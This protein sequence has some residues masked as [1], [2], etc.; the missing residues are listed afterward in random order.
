[1]AHQL[2]IDQVKAN[3]PD[4]AIEDNWTDEFIGGLLDSGASISRVTLAFWRGRVAKLSGVVDVTES[5]SSRQLSNLFNQ[6]K[7]AYDM[8]LDAVKLEDAPTPLPL[9]PSIAF[10]KL[11]RV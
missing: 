9:R 5:G 11:K 3:I 7:T 1:M 6:A 4:D 8:W 2:V 10:H